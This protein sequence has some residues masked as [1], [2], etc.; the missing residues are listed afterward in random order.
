MNAV[1]RKREILSTVSV[2]KRMSWAAKRE[3]TVL[4]DRA[5]LLLGIFNIN[6][7]I[8]YSEGVQAFINLQQQILK[9]YPDQSLFV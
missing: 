7:P 5:Y 8:L 1:I 3:T 4:K 9:Q 6:M 2:A